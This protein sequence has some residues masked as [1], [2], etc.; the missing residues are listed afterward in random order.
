M[1]RFCFIL[2]II[3]TSYY[4]KSFDWP[5]KEVMADSFYSYFGQYRGGVISPS[6]IFSEIEQIKASNTGKVNCVIRE[7]EDANF[8]ESTLGNAVI[9]IQEDNTLCVYGNLDGEDL[10]L[11]I[12]DQSQINTGDFIATSGNSAWQLGKNSLEFIVCDM[13]NRTVINPRLLMPRMGKELPLEVSGLCAINK[14]NDIVDF[15]VRRLFSAGTYLLYKD[16]QQVA[17]PYKTDTYVNGVV[18]EKLSYDTL[19]LVDNRM[20]ICGKHNYP[21]DLLYPD[22]KRQLLGEVILNR[23]HNT[24]SIVVTDILGIE[25]TTIYNIDCL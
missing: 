1:K 21:C 4:I 22:D 20:C 5:Q 19:H 8:F 10:T 13:R 9:T 25:K 7:H 18:V 23:G 11:D 24:I 6:I 3:C 15:S 14:N 2:L 12:K 16:R 17:V